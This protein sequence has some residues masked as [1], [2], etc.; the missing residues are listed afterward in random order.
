MRYLLALGASPAAAQLVDDLQ[1][2]FV[3]AGHHEAG[4]PVLLSHHLAEAARAA[5]AE[6]VVVARTLT[7]DLPLGEAIVALRQ[8]LPRARVVV[9]LGTPDEEARELARQAAHGAA[10]FDLRPGAVRP[11]DV[12]ALVEEPAAPRAEGTGGG[13][14]LTVLG[15]ATGAGAATVAA[16]LCFLL[17]GDGRRRSRRWTCGTT[18]GWRCCCTQIALSAG[19][20][21][22]WGCG[23][24]A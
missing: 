20:G 4:P 15:A 6:A 17:A 7:G 13:P 19:G 23:T 22:R 14:V 9:L 2:A 5:D 1:S 10:V 18:R 21:A 11:Q 16:N 3:A 8:A 12:R 24:W